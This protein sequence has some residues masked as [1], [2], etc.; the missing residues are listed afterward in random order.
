S[1]LNKMMQNYAADN[2]VEENEWLNNYR[3]SITAAA[4]RSKETLLRIKRLVN[5]AMEFTQVNYNFLYDDNQHLLSI[6]FNVDEHRRDG[7]FYDLL[8]SESRLTTYIAIAQGQLPQQSWFSLG[9]QLTSVGNSAILMSW[10]GSVFEYLMPLLVMPQYDNTLLSQ[11]NEALIKKE[12]E[13]GR[14]KS[15]PWGISES[16][17]NMFD[18]HLNYQYRAF[19]VP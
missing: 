7:G 18:A 14:K 13:Y 8:A 5:L 17:Y 11:T 10:S 3:A 6:G 2:T 19:G 16:G 9:R 4:H 15:T 12:I 1:L